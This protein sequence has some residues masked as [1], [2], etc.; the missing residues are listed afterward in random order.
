MKRKKKIFIIISNSLGEL[1]II[2]PFF[3]QLSLND[4][5]KIKIIFTVKRIYKKFL[6][7]DFYLHCIKLLKMKVIFCKM[8]SKFDDDYKIK[9]NLVN[10]AFFLIKRYLNNL[11]FLIKNID[12]LTYDY[13]L[14]DSSNQQHSTK[15]IRFISFIFNKN[16]YVF[17]H[18]H[19]L[20][21]A[22]PYPKIVNRNKNLTFLS[23][24]KLNLEWVNS[25]GYNKTITIGFPNFYRDWTIFTDNYS[26]KY[27][28]KKNYV[29]IFTRKPG[30]EYYMDM[31]KYISLI[32]ES[33]ITIREQLPEVDI[34]LKLHPRETKDSEDL[35]MKII[36]ENNFVN[37]KLIEEHPGVLANNAL[38][39]I[40]LWTSAI[41][42]SLAQKT[43]SIEFYKEAR[44]FREIEPLGSL[45]KYYGIDSVNNSNELRIFVQKVLKNEYSYPK[46]IDD[47]KLEKNINIFN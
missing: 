24:S 9:L 25:I 35:L 10:K 15:I 33:Y 37:I 34:Y 7:N 43:P 45:Y 14:H 23:Y 1:D 31:D 41:L 39:I 13:F 47:F 30:H 26:K 32:K 38:F 2:I 46:I 21:Q 16:L 20:N 18:G 27:G 3:Y 40:S 5:K 44:R 36:K 6:S 28:L 19:S 22:N 4:Q 29:V 17:H 12:I 42:I 11:N 8:E